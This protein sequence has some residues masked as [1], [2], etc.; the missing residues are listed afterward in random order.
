MQITTC[1]GIVMGRLRS[2][3]RQLEVELMRFCHNKLGAHQH[4]LNHDPLKDLPSTEYYCAT[5]EDRS[6]IAFHQSADAYLCWALL[7][8]RTADTLFSSPSLMS[9]YM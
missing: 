9:R 2:E 1:K 3:Q 8:A 5:G 4:T 7:T 6:E